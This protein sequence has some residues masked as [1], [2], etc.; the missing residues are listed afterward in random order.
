M[1]KQIIEYIDFLEDKAKLVD[2]FFV[3]R[4]EAIIKI[5]RAEDCIKQ[6]LCTIEYC[7]VD[8]KAIADNYHE[9]LKILGDDNNE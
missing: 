9:L 8:G 7:A 2:K 5:H 3:E 1:K 4:N 6:F